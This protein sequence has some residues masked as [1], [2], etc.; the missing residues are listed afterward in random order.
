MA[1]AVA[2]SAELSKD[3]RRWEVSKVKGQKEPIYIKETKMHQMVSIHSC[4]GTTVVVEGKVNSVQI[5][6]CSNTQV[7]MENVVGAV[8]VSNCTASA[9]ACSSKNV[10]FPILG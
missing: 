4:E 3:G 7:V 10:Y 6:K 9:R 8:E 5:D 2:M 1:A